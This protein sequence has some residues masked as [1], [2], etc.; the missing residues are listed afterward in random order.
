MWPIPSPLTLPQKHL[1]LMPELAGEAPSLNH[2]LQI[3]EGNHILPT[4]PTAPEGCTD[5]LGTE[6][7]H[8]ALGLVA[9]AAPRPELAAEPRALSVAAGEGIGLAEALR[10]PER[11]PPLV[12][13]PAAEALRTHERV[14]GARDTAAQPVAELLGRTAMFRSCSRSSC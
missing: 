7:P 8:S 3:S 9:R 13:L 5:P 14:L 10:H 4:H 11:I 12:A 1:Q 6:G 2:N